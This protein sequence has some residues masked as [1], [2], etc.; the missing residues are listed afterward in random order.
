MDRRLISNV[1]P[2]HVLRELA[3][4]TLNHAP[5]PRNPVPQ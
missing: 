5:P 1:A 3:L 4:I 2:P